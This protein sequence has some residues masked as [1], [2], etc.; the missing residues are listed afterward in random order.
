MKL[1]SETKVGMSHFCKIEVKYI[2]FPY[3]FIGQKKWPIQ[4]AE[5]NLGSFHKEKLVSWKK[6]LG[7]P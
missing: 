4:A 7:F 5:V 2:G 1:N 6:W 3:S